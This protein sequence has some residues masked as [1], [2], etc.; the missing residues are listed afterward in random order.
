MAKKREQALIDRISRQ[1]GKVIDLERTPGV[2]IE[3][4]REFGPTIGKVLDEDGV[5]GGGTGQTVSS[6][7]IAGPGTGHVTTEDLM[8]LLLEL[9]QEIIKLS[10]RVPGGG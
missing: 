2:L 9:R 3:I 4:L 8:R 1:Y 10:A 6:I 7:A 5:G